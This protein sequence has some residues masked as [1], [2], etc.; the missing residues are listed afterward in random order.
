MSNKQIKNTDLAAK[1]K[2]QIQNKRIEFNH[3]IP[4]SE[5]HLFLL[6]KKVLI[7]LK[8]NV[9]NIKKIM[10]IKNNVK[11]FFSQ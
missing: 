7:F 6:I 9:T 10:N 3:K 8:I 4:P 2:A 5:N 1:K 11:L